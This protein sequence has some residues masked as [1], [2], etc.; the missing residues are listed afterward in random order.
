MSEE[1]VAWKNKGNVHFKNYEWQKAIDMYSKGIEVDP[2]YH[3][4]YSN[5]SQAYF[6]LGEFEKARDDGAACIRAKPD[7][8]KGYHRLANAQYNLGDYIGCMKTVKSAE[9]NGFKNQKD[10]V[11]MY[12]R[13]HK[14]AEQQQDDLDAKLSG[15]EAIKVKANKLFKKAKYEDAVVEYTKALKQLGTI[16][17]ESTPENQKLYVDCLN[18]RALCK[19]QQQDWN[20]V[21][22]D[23]SAILEVKPTDLK[24]LYRRALAFE[25]I[26]RYRSAEQAIRACTQECFRIQVMTGNR[27]K[28]LD[29]ANQAQNRISGAVRKL[30]QTK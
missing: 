11:A 20:S 15:P 22:A 7:F 12:D 16:T 28:L 13:V 5:R 3:I 8:V 29:A 25:G 26:E 30:K 18:N 10:I 24:A 6:N 2:S 19:S 21:I 1:A 9:R 23:T 27:V 14:K 17:T 4:C